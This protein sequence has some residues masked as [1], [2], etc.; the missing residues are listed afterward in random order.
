MKAAAV[1][2]EPIQSV[3][4]GEEPTVVVVKP[5]GWVLA[6]RAPGS[7]SP[8]RPRLGHQ[9]VTG[10]KNRPRRRPETPARIV[11]KRRFAARSQ[12]SETGIR[13]RDTTIFSLELMGRKLPELQGLR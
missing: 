5:R 4:D 7:R 3:M 11:K 10:M 2:M 13:T 8:N 1:P 6:D 9:M 12:N